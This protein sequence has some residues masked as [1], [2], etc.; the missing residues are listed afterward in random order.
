MKFNFHESSILHSNTE[1][2]I[3]TMLGSN[4]DVARRL[5]N[6]AWF[7]VTALGKAIMPNMEILKSSGYQWSL[8][9]T[10]STVAREV[11]RYYEEICRMWGLSNLSCFYP[12][13]QFFALTSEG[14]SEVKLQTLRDLG[15]SDD[16]WK[17]NEECNRAFACYQE[18]QYI[19]T[20]RF[21]SRLS[22]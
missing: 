15:F 11:S 9:F 3:I 7:V 20:C 5:R 17:E 10:S 6:S 8:S 18:V 12:S 22:C 1:N 16:V 21:S 19:Q 13:C 4:H 14:M 2:K